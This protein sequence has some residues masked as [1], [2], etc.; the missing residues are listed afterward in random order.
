MDGVDALILY[1]FKTDPKQMEE[2][3]Y[4]EKYRAIDFQMKME[5][6]NMYL[7]VRKA[8]VEVVNEMFKKEDDN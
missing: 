4:I 8:V 3:E 5:R 2:A 7:S 1:R 6:Q